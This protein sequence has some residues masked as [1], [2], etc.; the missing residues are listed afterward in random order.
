MD[1]GLNGKTILITGGSKGIGLGIAK[2]CAAEGTNLVLV[3][4]TISLKEMEQAI[5]ERTGTLRVEA[6]DL[7]QSGTA[8]RLA[9]RFP[10]VDVLVNNAGAVP[11]GTI[12]DIDEKTWRAAWD[13]K[14]FGYINMCRAFYPVLAKRGGGSIIN[15]AGIGAIMKSP[16]SVC[17]STG[18]AAVVV[19]SQALGS[20]SHKDNIRVIAV[21]PGPVATER[22]T[23]VS[24]TQGNQRANTAAHL[25]YE[26]P[27]SVAEIGNSIAFLASPRS[28]YTSGAVLTIDGGLSATAQGL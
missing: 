9:Q 10:D 2:A 14:I 19:L 5:P 25:P 8:E 22:L 16:A 11:G 1:L 15:I 28:S 24:S 12:F 18:N 6:A 13:L 3:S 20:T 17:I 21:N 7:A 4:R 27:A 26:R 23:Q